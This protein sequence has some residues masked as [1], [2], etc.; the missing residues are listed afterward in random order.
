MSHGLGLYFM[1]FAPATL[2]SCI[3][4]KTSTMCPKEKLVWVLKRPPYPERSLGRA[5]QW[6]RGANRA[7]CG[8]GGEGGDEGMQTGQGAG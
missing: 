3:T 5:G 7:R 2:P 8:I 4:T 6:P 1:S